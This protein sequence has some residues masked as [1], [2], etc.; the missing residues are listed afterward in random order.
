MTREEQSI[1]DRIVRIIQTH[2]GEYDAVSDEKIADEVVQLVSLYGVTRLP[3]K[4]DVP[5]DIQV[6]HLHRLQKEV[7][8]YMPGETT[9][10]TI[11]IG[12]LAEMMMDVYASGHENGRREMAEA[13]QK[14]LRDGGI[15]A[16]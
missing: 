12:R 13:V 7:H 8:G 14:T 15:G 1:K 3:S 11:I 16:I 10:K 4:G 9:E 2:K 5:S 6:A